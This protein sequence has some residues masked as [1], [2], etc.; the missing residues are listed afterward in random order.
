MTSIYVLLDDRNEV[1]YVGLTKKSAAARLA[2]HLYEARHARRK[3]H[4]QNMLLAILNRGNRPAIRVFHQVPDDA[5]GD[6][7]TYW[8]RY[9][10]DLGCQLVNATDGGEGVVGLSPE[11]RAKLS[12]SLTGHFVSTETRALMRAIKTGIP[13]SSNH[14]ANIGQA[15]K[16]RPQPSAAI[17]QR[18]KRRK[19]KFL[20]KITKATPDVLVAYG[21]GASQVAIGRQF[22][23]T[24]STVR[25]I[26]LKAGVPVRDRLA[27]VSR[28]FQERNLPINL[29]EIGTKF[30]NAPVSQQGDT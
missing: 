24:R 25:E 6:A 3:T 28:P 1:R 10:R 27:S 18:Q 11:S 9:F 19:A 21:L 17:E 26:L 20:A 14:R 22:H 8:I 7:E 5:A 29:I 13:L 30:D 15:L 16:G 23:L 2:G 12:R 4:K